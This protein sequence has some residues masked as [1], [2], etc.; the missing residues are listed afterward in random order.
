VVAGGPEPYHIV[1]MPSW[2]ETWAV[3]E[4]IEEPSQS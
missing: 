3:T 2:G 1:S 4:K